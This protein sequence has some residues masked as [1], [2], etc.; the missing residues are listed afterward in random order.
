MENIKTKTQ[1]VITAFHNGLD[2]DRFNL[3]DAEL[4]MSPYFNI[5]QY[6]SDNNIKNLWTIK[7][8]IYAKYK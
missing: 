2:L 7:A 8:N 3:V 1:K 5:F 4:S 6:L